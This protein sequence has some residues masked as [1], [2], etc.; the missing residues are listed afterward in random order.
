[1]TF[2]KAITVIS[3]IAMAGCSDRTPTPAGE[4]F[5]ANPPDQ[6]AADAF[7]KQHLDSIQ[8]QSF[9][10]RRELCG[11]FFTA[12]DGSLRATPPTPGD[13]ASCALEYP[14]AGAGIYASYHTHGAYDYDYDNEVPSPD[15]LASDFEVGLDGY[16]ATPGGRVWL[17]EFD[18]KQAVQLCGRNCIASDRSF[19]PEDEAG[20]R[21][22]YTLPQLQDRQS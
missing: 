13:T 8:A 20:I 10:E 7:A 14:K 6:A 11:Y 17:V 21:P 22:T 4:P 12:S 16:V 2:A 1:M 9:A 3:F 18:T 19:V 15:D 5:A